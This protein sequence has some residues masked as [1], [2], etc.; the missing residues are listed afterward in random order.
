MYWFSDVAGNVLYVGK[1]KLLKRRVTSYTQLKR[2]NGR[3]R[4]MVQTASKVQ[5]K[6][7]ESEL[8]ALLTE[9]ELIRTYQPPSN[10]L[11]K[12]DKSPLYIHITKETF[13]KVVR[14][15]KKELV[16][17][18]NT[19]TVLGPFPSAY[20]VNE[21]LKIARSIFP[22]CAKGYNPHDLTPCFE[23]HIDLCPG[24]CLGKTS[25]S[26]YQD[27]IDN[28]ILFLK[29]K[30]KDVVKRM[31]D[32]LRAAAKAERFEQAAVLRD[33]IAIITE[34][35]GSSYK[36]KP[37]LSTA[38]LTATIATDGRAYL[39]SLLS[40][41]ANVPRTAELT[42]IEGYDVSNTQGT[43]ASVGMVVFTEGRADSGQYRMFNIRTLDTPNDYHM[44]QEALTR[45]QNHRG[46]GMPDLVVID[47]GKGQVRAVLKVWGW[48]CPVIGIAKDPDRLIIPNIYPDDVRPVT[49]KKIEYAEVKLPPTHPALKLVQQ[50]RDE[51]HRF[52][53]AQHGRRRIKKMLL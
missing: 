40:M 30:K 14:L 51:V 49:R 6:V 2:L 46:W 19:G 27:I 9:A 38:A 5:W 21:V 26:E 17:Q 50:V 32:Q 53:N 29:G 23:Y 37:E 47:G 43:L 22:W 7:L 25:A 20:K 33:K 16:K 34:V 8:E 45:R 36:L 44:L 11:L 39:R 35:T 42:R 52:S 48:Q 24:V 12:D 1:A 31:Q 41:H 3:I 13:P 4:T 28:L 18:K 15:R 10:V